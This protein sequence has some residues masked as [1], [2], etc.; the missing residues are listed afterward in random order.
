MRKER[1]LKTFHVTFSSVVACVK[2]RA[3]SAKEARTIALDNY[4]RGELTTEELGNMVRLLPEG[5]ELSAKFYA[6]VDI[7]PFITD[8][9]EGDG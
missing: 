7:E 9:K 6:S 1:Q 3:A 5:R 4:R 8:I 2:I